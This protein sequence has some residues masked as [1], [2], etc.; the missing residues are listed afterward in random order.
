MRKGD[1]AADFIIKETALFCR[2][3]KNRVSGSDG[4]HG[5]AWRLAKMLSDG[6]GCRRIKK[7]SFTVRPSAFY[8]F[9]KISAVLCLLA[10]AAFFLSPALSLALFVL[11]L[12]LLSARFVFYLPVTD[13]FFR[14]KRGTNLTAVRSCRGVPRRRILLNAHLDAAWEW[15]ANYEMGGFWVHFP[16]VGAAAGLFYMS[17]VDVLSLF[18]IDAGCFAAAGA[19]FVPFWI[20]QFCLADKKTVVDG[21]NDD[22]S[23]CLLALAV[24]HEL[25]KS[26]TVFENTEIGAV[27]TGG[28]ECGLTGARAWCKRHKKGSLPTYVVTVDTVCLPENLAVNLKDRNGTLRADKALSEL[29]LASAKEVGAPCKRSMMPLFGGA[30][31]A[32]EFIKAGYAAVSVTGA[33]HRLDR[34]Y[35]TRLDTAKS[36]CKE[37][38]SNCFE[39]IMKTVEKIDK[40]EA[41]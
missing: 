40:G 26:G 3:Y 32:A 16:C 4:E 12:A 21:A 22:M 10:Y 28:E 33:S 20:F 18:G 37:G 8:G 31:D 34:F 2:L 29:I 35:H 25:E 13:V 9:F 38:L 1:E 6:C 30:T 41:D 36:L 5:A 7:E 11:E 24:L 17:A 27:F 39:V 15:T 19:V 23:G 14:K